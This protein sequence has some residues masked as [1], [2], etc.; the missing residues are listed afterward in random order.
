LYFSWQQIDTIRQNPQSYSP[1]VLPFEFVS[2]AVAIAAFSALYLIVRHRR[3]GL[4]VGLGVW[5][6]SSVLTLFYVLNV[7]A[8]FAAIRNYFFLNAG[9]SLFVNLVVMYAF[10]HYLSQPPEKSAFIE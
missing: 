9:I 1:W 2:I 5:A 8:P 4:K 10:A 6:V 3:I 7:N